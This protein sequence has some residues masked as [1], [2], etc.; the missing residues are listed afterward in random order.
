MSKSCKNFQHP[1]SKIGGDMGVGV[2][3]NLF[4]TPPSKLAPMISVIFCTWATNCN[5]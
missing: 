3:K 1:G 5:G 2:K 4:P